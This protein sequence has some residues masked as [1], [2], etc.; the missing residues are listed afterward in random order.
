MPNYYCECCQ[1]NTNKHSNY[2]KHTKTKRHLGRVQL[3]ENDTNN[4]HTESNKIK[5]KYC[6]KEF[7]FKSGLSRHMKKNIV[8]KI[9]KKSSMN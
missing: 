5:C 6:D 4:Y 7:A 1:Y 9:N 3:Y 2:L 8:N